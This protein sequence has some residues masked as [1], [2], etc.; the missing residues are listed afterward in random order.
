MKY[1]KGEREKEIKCVNAY[2]DMCMREYTESSK[3]VC[4][5]MSVHEQL[6]LCLLVCT[7]EIRINKYDTGSVNIPKHMCA[8]ISY[9]LDLTVL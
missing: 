2:V 9:S 5:L 3:T 7:L 8:V 1:R 4:N 6:H